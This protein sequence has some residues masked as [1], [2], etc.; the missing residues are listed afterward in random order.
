VRGIYS[1]DSDATVIRPT[2]STGKHGAVNVP[3]DRHAEAETA[4]PT[5]KRDRGKQP[6][7]IAAAASVIILAVSIG[8]YYSFKPEEAPKEERVIAT[9][10]D[11]PED[12]VSSALIHAKTACWHYARGELKTDLR[13]IFPNTVFQ[14]SNFG[15]IPLSLSIKPFII[16]CNYPIIAMTGHIM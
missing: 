14:S 3:P 11:I 16:F 12:L 9:Q 8:G 5:N 13:Q 7:L 4:A 2:Y 15:A 1:G 6:L 10:R